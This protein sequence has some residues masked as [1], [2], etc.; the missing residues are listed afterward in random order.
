MGTKVKTGYRQLILSFEDVDFLEEAQ[1]T[2]FG[3]NSKCGV[4]REYENV[5]GF[6]NL[7]DDGFEIEL[8][9]LEIL[10]DYKGKDYGKL[11]I[12]TIFENYP[13]CEEIVGKAINN[14]TGFYAQIGADIEDACDGCIMDNCP[15]SPCFSEVSDFD[16]N[17]C[18]DF[19]SHLFT[20]K[21][22]MFFELF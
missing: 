9:E 18:D 7:S 16:Y 8:H 1:M 6:F 13:G 21:K 5:I 2:E 11:F 4:I 22:D 19:S 3:F 17:D 15:N 20:L 14:S 12:K 10:E